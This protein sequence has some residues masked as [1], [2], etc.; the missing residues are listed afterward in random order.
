MGRKPP[1]AETIA[2]QLRAAILASGQSQYALAKAAG[3]SQSVLSRFVA[4]ER[5]MTLATA[6]KLSDHLGLELRA[7]G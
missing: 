4:A 3:V 6:C 2:D 5:D 1:R 7:K